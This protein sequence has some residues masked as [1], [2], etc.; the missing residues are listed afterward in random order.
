MSLRE[1]LASV[2]VVQR[3]V[4]GLDCA[5]DLGAVDDERGISSLS[6]RARVRRILV[7][8]VCVMGGLPGASGRV[9]VQESSFR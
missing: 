2:P 6:L 4:R 7:H 9:C 8:G 5:T 3:S 1:T